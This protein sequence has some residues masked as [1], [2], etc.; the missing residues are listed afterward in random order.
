MQGLLG[1]T[2]H[3]FSNQIQHALGRGFQHAS[4]IYKHWMRDGQVASLDW[5]EPQALDLASQILQS[6]QL[7]L[8]NVSFVQEEEKTIKYLLTFPDGV[9]SES[10]VIPMAS[11][12][13]LCVSSQIGCQRGCAFCQTAT[14]GIVRSLTAEEIVSQLF[15]AKHHFRANIR[16]IV[17]MGMGEP[18]DNFENVMQAI[19]VMIDPQGFGF[20]PSRITVSTSGV[21]PMIYAFSKRADPA[22]NLAVSINAP[23][24]EVRRKLMPVNRFWDMKALKEAMIEY[25]SHPRRGILVEY[26]LL[27]GINDSPVDA[28]QLADYLQGLRVKVNLIPYNAQKKSRFC[29]PSAFVQ[30]AFLEKLRQ[31]GLKALLRHHKG[32][33]IMAACGQ[34]GKKVGE[35]EVI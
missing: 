31:R 12:S 4:K 22:L 28:D 13:T 32:R 9:Q 35:K 3:Q 25:L 21:V 27:E 33:K 24:D 34:L 19:E 10:V 16:N 15:I 29:A 14:M 6:A 17:F 8:P 1:L 20:G 30:E 2:N 5:V 11:F 18:L 7:N 23:N 26:V